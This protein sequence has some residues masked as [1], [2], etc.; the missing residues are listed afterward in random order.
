MNNGSE[1]PSSY[2]FNL[3]TWHTI[4]L[5][6]TA[7][8]RGSSCRTCMRD[9]REPRQARLACCK[10]IEERAGHWLAM[11]VEE[12]KIALSDAAVDGKSPLERLG[13]AADAGP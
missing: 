5:A 12:G 2:Y 11:K 7:R 13:R 1:V 9:A 8:R 3:A 6:Y 4:N 10:L